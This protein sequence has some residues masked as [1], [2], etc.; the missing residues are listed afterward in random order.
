MRDPD[1]CPLPQFASPAPHP[2]ARRFPQELRPPS[3]PRP[4]PGPRRWTGRDA[5]PWPLTDRS[6]SLPSR[7][8]P[9]AGARV[10][11]V[12]GGPG[13]RHGRLGAVRERVQGPR[14]DG[15]LLRH[16]RGLP[17]RPAG[18]A[19]GGRLRLGPGTQGGHVGWSEDVAG[20]RGMR[21]RRARGR[22]AVGGSETMSMREGLAR[23][24]G[25]RRSGRRKG[26]RVS[27]PETRRSP[28]RQQRKCL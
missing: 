26:E 2:Q 8:G 23:R 28:P 20:V 17:C 4:G 7:G 10:G 18:A 27:A 19:G 22:P 9:R 13:A 3:F 12:L 16:Q 6:L 21:V 24:S 5:C 1:L 11:R 14:H 15:H 25:Q